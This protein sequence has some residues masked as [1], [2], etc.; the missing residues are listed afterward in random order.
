MKYVETARK[1]EAYRDEIAA[2]RE[3]IRAAQAKTEPQTVEDYMFKTVDGAVKL[4]ALFGDKQ[5]LILIHNMGK[6]CSHCT[7][8]ADGFNGVYPHLANRA[9]FVVSSPDAPD[10]QR[11]FAASRGWRFPMVSHQGSSFAA[12]MG[13]RTAKGGFLPGV[14]VFRRPDKKDGSKKIARV[15]D[16]GFHEENDFCTVWRLFDLLPDG[17]GDWEAQFKYE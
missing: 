11:K 16:T 13:Y 10:V 4:S 2:L 7:M 17:V 9:A 12:D 1:V 5:D 6:G 15:A 8:W 14:S 3:K